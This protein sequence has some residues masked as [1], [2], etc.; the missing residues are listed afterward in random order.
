MFHFDLIST[1]TADKMM[2]IIPGNFIDQS[3]H[4]RFA[5]DAPDPFSARNSSV[6]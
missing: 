6:R 5:R 2:M 1:D 3:D 4:Y